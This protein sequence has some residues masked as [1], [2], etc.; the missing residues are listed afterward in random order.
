MYADQRLLL[1]VVAGIG[2]T[3][4]VNPNPNPSSWLELC[5]VDAGRPLDAQ[6]A[7]GVDPGSGLT[8]KG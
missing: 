6:Q 3:P 2:L 7:A 8:L 5:G 4:G 1:L